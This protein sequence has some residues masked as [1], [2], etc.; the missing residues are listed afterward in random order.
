MSDE[1][2]R[3]IAKLI[4]IGFIVA[5]IAL[6][7]NS[8][9]HWRHSGSVGTDIRQST[10]GT[11]ADIE[12]ANESASREIR[13]SREHIVRAEEHVEGAADAVER[14]EEAAGINA[15]RTEQLEKLISESRKLAQEN[16][17]IMRDVEADNRKRT[18]GI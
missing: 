6:V 13:D 8:I 12:R 7:G 15:E 4:K 11:M 3:T 5:S 17:R 18:E 9:W 10:D 1:T 2:R 14:S 16:Q